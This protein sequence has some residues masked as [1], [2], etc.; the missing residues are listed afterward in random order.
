MDQRRTPRMRPFVQIAASQVDACLVKEVNLWSV[1]YS[2]LYFCV[3]LRTSIK[4]RVQV[5]QSEWLCF[6]R[7][8]RVGNRCRVSGELVFSGLGFRPRIP[9]KPGKGGEVESE[10]QE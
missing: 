4:K 10:F 5:R 9:A 3:F 2:P 8:Q 7:V 6:P 1:S